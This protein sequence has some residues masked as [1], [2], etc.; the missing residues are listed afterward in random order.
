MCNCCAPT[1]TSATTTVGATRAHDIAQAA[2][3]GCDGSCGCGDL[4][5]ATREEQETSLDVLST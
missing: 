1:P 2:D 5:A 3:C 4:P